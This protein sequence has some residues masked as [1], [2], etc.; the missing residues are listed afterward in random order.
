MN[1]LPTSAFDPAGIEWQR[2]SPKLRTAR[3]VVILETMIV[4][5]IGSVVLAALIPQWWTFAIAGVLV[6]LTVWFVWLAYR[7]VA[8]IGY[9]ERAEDLLIR[10]GIMFRS[11]VVV[12]YGRMQEVDVEVG[13]L[14]RKF[15]IAKITLHTASAGTNAT[16]P[17][18]PSEEAARLRDRLASLGE[19]RLAGL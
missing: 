5:L 2:V 11:L 19:S 6:A 16:L 18:L 13:P 10:R 3:I 15:G 9:A 1:V 8:A 12:P 7:Q 4:P 14:D 17:G